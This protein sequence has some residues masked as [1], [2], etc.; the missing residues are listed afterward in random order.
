MPTSSA[1]PSTARSASDPYA[2][3]ARRGVWHD[4][5]V[6]WE[7]EDLGS[8]LAG[9]PYPGRGIVWARTLD[10]R[11]AAGYF[12][13]GRTAAS[14]ARRLRADGDELL[15]AAL[16]GEAGH[17]PL[18]HYV[19]ARQRG[20]RL[21][22]G[23]GEQVGQVADRLAAGVTPPEALAGL[24]YEPD[25]PVFTPRITAV[26]DLRDGVAWFGSA[27]RPR[28]LRT[29]P[30]VMTLALS[31]PAPGDALLMTTYRSDG[32]TVATA[33]PYAETRTTASDRHELLTAIWSALAPELRVAATTF[34][35]H[36]LAEAG[37]LN[38]HP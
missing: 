34:E 30:D 23:N 28:G 16:G 32:R 15:A 11:L 29:E 12:M 38:R 4:P 19:A 3:G 8:V 26:A 7:P 17:D 13:T 18:R 21:V 22:Y 35:P 24:S 33:E 20:D 31:E 36:R 2:G 37:I 10:G 1:R 9:N 25:P 6:T 14:Q 5:R 27:R